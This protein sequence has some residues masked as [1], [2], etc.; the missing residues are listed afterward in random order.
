[1]NTIDRLKAAFPDHEWW[2]G[3]YQYELASDDEEDDR[4][5]QY[6]GWPTRDLC[7]SV[8]LGSRGWSADIAWGKNG[9]AHD[10]GIF[11]FTN[12]HDT[13]SAAVSAAV[14]RATTKLGGTL[15]VLQN[16]GQ[17]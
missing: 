2:D 1:V 3:W 15:G 7:I 9:V 6:C 16:V 13:P 11:T 4:S 17:S 12:E 10:S 14:E 5:S 8:S